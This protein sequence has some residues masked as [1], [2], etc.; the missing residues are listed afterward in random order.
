M[1]HVLFIV[2]IGSLISNIVCFGLWRQSATTRL[3]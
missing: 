3:Q 1:I 2:L